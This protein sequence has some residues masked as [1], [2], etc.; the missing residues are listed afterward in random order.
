MS[1]FSNDLASD[2]DKSLF[3]VLERLFDVCLW[4]FFR[5]SLGR[6]IHAFHFSQ[7]IAASLQF[8]TSN[9]CLPKIMPRKK[10]SMDDVTKRLL[11]D[12]FG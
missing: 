12:T 1:E 4:F 9:F 11:T 10:R 3:F 5:A 7:C 6:F 2:L 8:Q